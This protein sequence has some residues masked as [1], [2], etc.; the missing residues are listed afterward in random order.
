MRTRKKFLAEKM[1]YFPPKGFRAI[2]APQDVRLVARP[3]FVAGSAKPTAAQRAGLAYE[4]KACAFLHDQ[5]DSG[6]FGPGWV[7]IRG[8]WLQ[9]RRPTSKNGYGY[10][11]PDMLLL[12][13]AQGKLLIVE[14]K[15]RLCVEAWWQLMRC[16][17]P[18]LQE[19]FPSHLW[20]IGQVAVTAN[21][22][23]INTPTPLV[24]A[25]TPVTYAGGADSVG[26]FVLEQSRAAKYA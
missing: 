19:L 11:Q 4:R 17:R 18:L 8:P 9:Y 26:L 15:L 12:N 3:P 5:C 25:R 10:A 2:E 21:S 23:P 7:G 13:P 24:Y 22:A 1:G 16:Y 20:V 14:I 6:A